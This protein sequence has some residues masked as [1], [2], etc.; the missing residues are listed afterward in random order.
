MASATSPTRQGRRARRRAHRGPLQHRT[1]IFSGGA[2]NRP[3]VPG[4]RLHRRQLHRDARNDPPRCRTWTATASTTPTLERVEAGPGGKRPAAL[5]SMNA[6]GLKADALPDF[7]ALRATRG[8]ID[9]VSRVQPAEEDGHPA[10][11]RASGSALDRRRDRRRSRHR[12]E[13]VTGNRRRTLAAG[14]AARLS[15]LALGR[16]R[17]R[18]DRSG[19]GARS[20]PHHRRPR[21]PR[22]PRNQRARDG[23]GA[24]GRRAIC[25]ARSC[26]IK[27]CR[28]VSR[29][30]SRIGVGALYGGAPRT[31]NVAPAGHD[32]DVLLERLHSD[33][34]PEGA[35]ASSND[36]S[37]NTATVSVPTQIRKIFSKS[38]PKSA[39]TPETWRPPRAVRG[40]RATG[41]LLREAARGAARTAL[42]PQ[43]R[44]VVFAREEEL[45]QRS[46]RGAFPYQR[47]RFTADRRLW[48]RCATG[49]GPA[50]AEARA[51]AMTCPP[52]SVR[53]S[54]CSIGSNGGRQRPARRRDGGR[55]E[56]AQLA[57]GVAGAVLPHDPGGS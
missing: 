33:T 16:R 13:A 47:A 19:R 34:V 3:T 27:R 30:S 8:F 50:G 6:A 22:P 17:R 57:Q 10:P 20:A 21:G 46:A 24:V 5:L 49:S 36:S 23:P 11:K 54:T 31:R 55:P 52:S 4:R 38:P 9:D 18:V 7:F 35:A 43:Q 48:E 25:R 2:G 45:M 56:S 51:W 14:K 40:V 26:S 44:R 15:L 32:Y 12:R 1:Y 37:A 28:S 41:A 39:A 53:I 42:H 29:F